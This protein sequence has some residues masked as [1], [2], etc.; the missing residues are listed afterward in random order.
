MG[1]EAGDLARACLSHLG[2]EEQALRSTLETL[3]VV[4]AAAL[5]ADIGRLED[6]RGLQD[7]SALVTESLRCERDGLRG[8]IA[9]LL[10]IPAADATLE[11][12]ALHL[13]GPSGEYLRSAAGRVRDLAGRVDRL[14]LSNA[15][16]LEYCLGFTR[17]VLRDLTGGGTP[18]ESYGPDGTVT[19]SPCGPLLSAKG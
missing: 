2:R 4:R 11:S 10:R 17:R 14:N 12:L 18:A 7:E 13:G 9:T 1:T 16:V 3:G 15:T 19:E 6:L 5:A 8:R